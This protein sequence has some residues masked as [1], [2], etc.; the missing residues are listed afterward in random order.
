MDVLNI[1]QFLLKGNPGVGGKNK[2]DF[3]ILLE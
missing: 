1:C 2:I 3:G